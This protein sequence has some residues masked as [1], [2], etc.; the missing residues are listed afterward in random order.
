MVVIV[1]VPLDGLRPD[2]VGQFAVKLPVR[3]PAVVEAVPDTTAVKLPWPGWLEPYDEQPSR[4]PLTTADS[5]CALALRPGVRFTLPEKLVQVWTVTQPAGLT[6]A[7][8]VA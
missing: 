5:A 7:W 3:V 2:D 4:V 1:I 8:A 6:E